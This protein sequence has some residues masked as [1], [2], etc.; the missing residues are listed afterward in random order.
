MSSTSLRPRSLAAI[1]GWWAEELGVNEPELSAHAD[2]VTLSP[3][4]NVPGIFLFRRGGDLRIGAPMH[5]VNAIHDAL[6]GHPI[7][8]FMKPKFW[9][10]KLPDFCGIGVGPALLH[11]LDAA[12]KSW[13]KPTPRGFLVRGLAPMDARAVAD[14][15]EALTPTEREHSGVEISSRGLWG[16]FEGRNLVAI[17][18]SDPWPNRLAHVGVA[19]HPERRGRKLAQL[20]VQAAARGSIARRRI[21]QYRTLATNSASVGVA[22][23]LGMEVFAETLY[24]RPVVE[25]PT[26]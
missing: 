18:S 6:I 17:A 9:R 21:V 14:F 20:V 25:K 2:G 3:S 26:A 11:Y 23:A 12:P 4:V 15:A 1:L 24:V 7:A 8:K 19:V 16:V 22:R 5:Q 13:D 10:K